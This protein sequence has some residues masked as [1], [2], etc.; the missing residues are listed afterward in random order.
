MP[1]FTL[2][3]SEGHLCPSYTLKKIQIMIVDG[4][5]WFGLRFRFLF[6]GFQIEYYSLTSSG[7]DFV[8]ILSNHPSI[9]KVFMYNSSYILNGNSPK[10]YM[11]WSS[12]K[13]I[14]PSSHPNLCSWKIG[15]L[16][17]N[18]NQ[19]LISLQNEERSFHLFWSWPSVIFR[20]SWFD[21]KRHHYYCIYYCNSE[22]VFKIAFVW[23]N[24]INEKVFDFSIFWILILYHFIIL[25][26]K[27]SHK[28][29][30]LYDNLWW[31]KKFTRKNN[32]KSE[33][34]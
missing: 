8:F 26:T 9:T 16:A 31:N 10:L 24:K 19:S 5:K 18:K 1:L 15:H 33:V 12:T 30:I 11:C 7:G 2:A 6:V 23:Q 21:I 20:R 17:L 25:E 13:Q 32:F 3:G 14:S 27:N 22:C 34:A 4:V 29:F 28:I